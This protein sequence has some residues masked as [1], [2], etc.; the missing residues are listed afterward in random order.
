MEGFKSKSKEELERQVNLV[1]EKTENEI[2]PVSLREDIHKL[3]LQEMKKL[4]PERYR[5]Y[6]EL[7][8]EVKRTARED[9]EEIVAV[10]NDNE[11]TE[12]SEDSVWEGAA[13]KAHA[14]TVLDE[15][16]HGEDSADLNNLFVRQQETLL[17]VHH[18]LERGIKRGYVDL[19]TGVGKTIIFSKL[20]KA[21][22]SHPKGRVLVVGP[23][24]IIQ[25][26]NEGKI[27]TYGDRKPGR[28]FGG[29]KET[30]SNVTLTTYS[31]FMSHAD[32]LDLD[33]YDLIILDESHRALSEARVEM[34]NSLKKPVIIGFSA[35]QEFHEDKKIEDILDYEIDS[36]SIKEAVEG[37]L[38]SSLKVY[39]VNTETNLDVERV[40]TDFDARALTTAIDTPERNKLVADTY[41][42]SPIL[43]G[44]KAV[45]YC[46]TRDHARRIAQ[47]LNAQGA[48]AAYIGGDIKDYERE[49]LLKQF[50]QGDLEVLC[51]ADIL[52]EGFDAEEAEVCLNVTP[53]LSKVNA[54]QR[55]GRV[56]RRNKGNARKVGKVIEFVDGWKDGTEKPIL[57]SEIAGAAELGVQGDFAA[58]DEPDR[59]IEKKPEDLRTPPDIGPHLLESD[60]ELVMSVT[61]KFGS[62]RLIRNFEYAPLLWSNSR[63]LSK[64]THVRENTIVAFAERFRVEKPEWFKKCLTSQNRLALHYSPELVTRIRKEFLSEL[65]DKVNAFEF[66]QKQDIPLGYTEELFTLIL[67][68][69]RGIASVVVGGDIF[70]DEA[71]FAQ[72]YDRRDKAEELRL[73]RKEKK[74]LLRLLEDEKAPDA[75]A[76]FVEETDVSP[77]FTREG[78]AFEHTEPITEEDAIT[79]DEREVMRQYLL[80]SQDNS[81]EDETADGQWELITQALNH[82][83]SQ[84][85]QSARLL[86]L[87]Y[88]EGLGIEEIS[89][90]AN[91]KK[92]SVYALLAIARRRL[93][94]A[95]EWVTIK[96]IN[97]PL[98]K[99]LR[100]EK[101]VFV[102]FVEKARKNALG[103]LSGFVR[104]ATRSTKESKGFVNFCSE[105]KKQIR[106]VFQ[107]V[108]AISVKDISTIYA[109][110]EIRFILSREVPTL[111]DNLC[112]Q[113][114][115]SSGVIEKN[116]IMPSSAFNNIKMRLSLYV[117]KQ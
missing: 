29:E 110:H 97:E 56:L 9:D 2:T 43:K 95:V 31:S 6:V 65:Q 30:D 19:P 44:R 72:W 11:S 114:V 113:F 10:S 111:V 55:G 51:N 104:G 24:K 50:R 73:E 59:S 82:L 115:E 48:Q 106:A 37:G 35:T 32:D 45:A 75:Q 117:K 67:E 64:E 71:A 102:N 58:G 21:F 41:C 70:I 76:Q 38:L 79:E 5:L 78:E 39:V 54:E 109:L 88:L 34:I 49:E 52:I 84:H 26:Q 92:R 98:D 40:G 22:S 23:T 89:K 20:V 96:Q 4:Y 105:T 116:R 112:D 17:K 42:N 60:P 83:K 18:C 28:Y 80:V 14:L 57:F 68:E 1:E 13:V 101:I 99:H 94:Q 74:A 16:L 86:E 66:S 8:R 85:P 69:K 33:S 108:G 81:F 53:T 27:E 90:K 100:Y 46:V 77:S 93:V 47:Q 107:T 15:M 63:N 61:K 7:L 87:K 103:R 3:S 62:E 12:E 36:M 91:V 25:E